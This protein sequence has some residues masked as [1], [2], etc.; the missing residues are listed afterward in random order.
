MRKYVKIIV[1]AL[2]LHIGDRPPGT[3]KRIVGYY[4]A[5]TM[6]RGVRDISCLRCEFKN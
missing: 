1:F 2:V 4:S 5:T 3:T 6:G